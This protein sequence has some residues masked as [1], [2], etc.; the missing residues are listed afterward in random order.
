MRLAAVKTLTEKSPYQSRPDQAIHLSLTWND[1]E[2]DGNFT[3]WSRTAMNR[4]QF[5][6]VTTFKGPAC[7]STGQLD[8]DFSP[9]LLNHS[10]T[11]PKHTFCGILKYKVIRFQR[12]FFRLE[13]RD[14]ATSTFFERKGLLKVPTLQQIEEKQIPF[15]ALYSFPK[16]L[17]P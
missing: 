17:M 9:A 7:I 16:R 13:D 1:F 5:F 11:H 8:T 2:F 14:I 3:W 6:Y 10:S 15:V 12:I 4:D